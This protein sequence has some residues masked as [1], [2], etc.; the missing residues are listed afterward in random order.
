MNGTLQQGYSIRDVALRPVADQALSGLNASSIST[1]IYD[2]P[3]MLTPD[4]EGR[5]VSNPLPP[6]DH[7]ELNVSL[8]DHIALSTDLF[9]K[10]NFIDQTVSP[11]FSEGENVSSTLS[12]I[13]NSITNSIM[14]S[15]NE[16]LALGMV[17]Q[18]QH[19]MKV[20]WGWLA[21]PY[22]I[23]VCSAT[24]LSSTIVASW[25]YDVPQ[26]KSS[27]LPLIFHGIR[28]W[29][30]DDKLDLAK[31]RLEKMYMMEDTACS[32][33]VQLRRGVSGGRWLAE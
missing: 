15:T 5:N 29:N 13:A 17:W 25:H 3:L 12:N 16:T 1:D 28:D 18:Q 6:F 11:R 27:P 2:W 9:T 26:W 22:A 14:R 20:R 32:K 24:L 30:E 33:K 31:G 7:S 19:V 8:Y 10:F 23:V 4:A 21:L